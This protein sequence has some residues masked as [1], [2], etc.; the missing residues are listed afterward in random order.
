MTASLYHQLG[1]VAQEQRQWSEAESNYKQALQ[2]K[3]DFNDRHSQASTY[4]QLGTVA[5]DQQ[6]WEQARAYLLEALAIYSEYRDGHNSGI[7]LRSLARV[8]KASGDPELP[9]AVADVLGVSPEEAEKL[10]R[11]SET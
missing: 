7:V 2:I 11:S 5:E 8:W 1:Y 4:H 10:L 6:Q 9:K 3:I